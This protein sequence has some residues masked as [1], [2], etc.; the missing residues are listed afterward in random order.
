LGQFCPQVPNPAAIFGKQAL[1]YAALFC[2]QVKG[3]L[4][5]L[6]WRWQRTLPGHCFSVTLEAQVAEGGQPP[7]IEG[8][9]KDQQTYPKITLHLLLT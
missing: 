6:G 5:F 7:E 1:Q 9:G 2:F 8:Q 4:N 3:S